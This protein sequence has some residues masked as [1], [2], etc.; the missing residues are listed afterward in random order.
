MAQ[1]GK[2]TRIE[3]EPLDAALILGP[4]KVR[5]VLPNVPEEEDAPMQSVVVVTV[6]ILIQRND[7]DFAKY[8]MDRWRAIDEVVR[9]N[10]G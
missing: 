4:N 6:A 8:I 2:N 3:L 9:E 7:P 10:G 1:R 5:Y